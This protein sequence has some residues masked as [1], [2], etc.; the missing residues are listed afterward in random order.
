MK[1]NSIVI[2]IFLIV[3]TSIIIELFNYKIKLEKADEDWAWENI[4]QLHLTDK[5]LVEE[6]TK[7]KLRLNFLSS[8][9][10]FHFN[11][12]IIKFINKTLDYTDNFFN[13][14]RFGYKNI[15]NKNEKKLKIN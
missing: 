11:Y 7:N 13:I 8:N 4:S 6:S 10:Y 9:N 1:K 3:I 12:Y 14:K 2:I 15:I 5:T